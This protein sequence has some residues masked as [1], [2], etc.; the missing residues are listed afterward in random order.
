MSDNVITIDCHHFFPEVAAAYLL[1]EGRRAAFIENNTQYAVPRLLSAL[2]EHGLKPE[3]VEYIIITHVHLDHAGGTSAL[4][5]E[6]TEAVV[7]AHER[8]ARHVID[9]EKLITSA[10]AVYGEDN[11]KRIFGVIEP[12]DEGRVR[13]VEDGET[14]KL[15]ERKL[16][17]I[18]TLGHAKHHMCIYDSHSNG[19]LTGDSFGIAFP[20]LQGGKRSF[21]YP[22]TSPTDFDPE[23][24][25]KS[26]DAILNTGADV[27]YLTH[28]GL[29]KE[30]KEG[31][32]MMIEYINKMENILKDAI[33]S[34]KDS[35]CLEKYC[36]ERVFKFFKSE[37]ESRGL[38]LSPE[39]LQYV[40]SDI[41]L[42]AQGIAFIAQKRINE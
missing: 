27:A 19:I 40:K 23:E 42:N 26:I 16:R 2:R 14:I 25:R 6:C 12:L 21:L 4:A 17:F 34:G 5:K 41:D 32:E 38:R 18:Y 8:A 1:I 28:F 30:M 39:I 29:F 20:A 31:A 22:S 13:V 3:D 10:T 35:V 36:K 7:L 15:G 37:I 24:A 33:N 11:F 9:P